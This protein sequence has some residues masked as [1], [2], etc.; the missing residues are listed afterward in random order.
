MREGFHAFG[1]WYFRR[2]TDGHVT[3][4]VTE[5]AQADAPLARALTV[6]PATWASIVAS[7]SAEGESGE[8]WRRALDYHGQQV[9]S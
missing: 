4:E 8:R 1:G 9:A 3:I 5:T 2:D 7:V 6:D